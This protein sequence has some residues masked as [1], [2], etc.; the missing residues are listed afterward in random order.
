MSVLVICASSDTGIDPQRSIHRIENI[1]P[2]APDLGIFL[3]LNRL[4]AQAVSVIPALQTVVALWSSHLTQTSTQQTSSPESALLSRSLHLLSDALSVATPRL[5]PQ[6]YM[7]ILQTEVLLAYYLQRLCQAPNARYHATAALSLAAGLG[8]HFKEGDITTTGLLDFVSTTHPRLPPA[9]D[10]V[11]AQERV[12][13][14][15]TIFSLS[16]F[17]ETGYSGSADLNTTIKVT[18][19][20][21]SSAQGILVSCIHHESQYHPRKV[22]RVIGARML[23]PKIQSSNFWLPRPSGFNS[24]RRLA[25]RQEQLFCL[26]KHSPSQRPISEVGLTDHTLN[27]V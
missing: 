24:R 25:Y 10:L 6:F 3:N 26:E 20:W 17:L 27:V 23:Q 22:F 19:P 21:P 13:A 1:L 15:W 16:K 2:H 18:A 11:E 8:L 9:T 12:D 4:G 7:Q 5:G 14:W